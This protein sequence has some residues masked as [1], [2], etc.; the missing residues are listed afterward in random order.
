[1]PSD[2]YDEPL[3]VTPIRNAVVVALPRTSGVAATPEAALASARRL[4]EAAHLAMFGN[5]A[6]LDSGD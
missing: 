6:P 2:V 3:T 5:L 1:M 4:M